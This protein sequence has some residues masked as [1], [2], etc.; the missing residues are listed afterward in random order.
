M[1]HKFPVLTVKKWLKSVFTEVIAK[2]KLGYRFFGP[3][4]TFIAMAVIV[5]HAATMVRSR[6]L[7]WLLFYRLFTTLE[8]TASLRSFLWISSNFLQTPQELFLFSSR[9]LWCPL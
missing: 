7:L 9:I 6:H 5:Y 1:R 3:P 4:C 2:I 8:L